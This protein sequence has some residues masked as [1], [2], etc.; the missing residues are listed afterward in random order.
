M[1]FPHERVNVPNSLRPARDTPSGE[2]RD[3]AL[4]R[5][6]QPKSRSATCD[7][8]CTAPSPTSTDITTF[9][10]ARN[11]W[12]R[13]ASRSVSYENVEY[14]LSAPHSPAPSSN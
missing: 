7:P 13:S 9:A 5:T 4:G 6:P 2:H 8:R 3:E 10:A 14:V 1:N 11:P 12:P